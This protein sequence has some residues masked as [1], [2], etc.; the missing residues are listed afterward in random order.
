MIDYFINSLD[1]SLDNIV[2]VDCTCA[3]PWQIVA[4]PDGADDGHA[5]VDTDCSV[6]PWMDQQVDI[7]TPSADSSIVDRSNSWMWCA[8]VSANCR[9]YSTRCCRAMN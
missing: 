5:V 6:Y 9:R 1:R 8:F 2:V 7:V 4:A 3:I